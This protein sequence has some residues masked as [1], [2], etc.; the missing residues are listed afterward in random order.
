MRVPKFVV[1][2]TLLF[3]LVSVGL[4]FFLILSWRE[5]NQVLRVVDGDSFDLKDGRRI[6]LLGIDTPEKNRCMYEEARERLR[7]MIENRRLRME[8]TLIDDYGRILA[9][10]FVGNT[11]VNK[12]MLEEG[13]ARFLYVKSPY[14]DELKSSFLTAK[15]ER[16]GVFSATCSSQ[17]LD[18]FI[19]GNIRDGDKIYHL[20]GCKNYSQVEMQG[21]FGDEWFCSEQEALQAGFRKV[22]GCK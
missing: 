10:V 22:E 20:P 5:K 19:K 11:L 9:N 15:T 1:Y 16:I 14:Y 2:L 4:N 13:L 7:Q 18:C 6:R 21:A 12:V 3:F 17:P 8:N